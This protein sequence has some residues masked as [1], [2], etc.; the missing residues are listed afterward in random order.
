MTAG[1]VHRTIQTLDRYNGRGKLVQFTPQNT[2]TGSYIWGYNQNY[3]IAE[4][5]NAPAHRVFYGNFE[6]DN[7][8]DANL[9]VFRPNIIGNK[10]RTGI[11][12][13]K[14][15]KP[16]VGEKVSHSTQWLTIAQTTSTKYHYSGW[17]YSD[18]PSADI[19]LFMKRANEGGYFSYVDHVATSETGKWVYIEKDFLVPV[20]VA[21][22]NIRVD[23]NGGGNVWFDDIRLHPTD[24]QMTTSQWWVSLPSP[25]RHHLLRLRLFQSLAV[26]AGSGWQ[27][28]QKL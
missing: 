6:E 28:G 27:P 18:G 22:L 4:V 9:I 11:Y 25:M 8:W 21:Q 24:A 26:R 13:G 17:V 14:I 10:V 1:T 12:S 19:F 20:D 2:Y 16:T 7:Q 23:N 15:E 3:P 5:K